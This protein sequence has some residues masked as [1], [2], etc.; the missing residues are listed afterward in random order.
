[1]I[2]GRIVLAV[3]GLAFGG[4]AV[5]QSVVPR[6]VRD[7]L[8]HPPARVPFGVG[9]VLDYGIAVAFARGNARLEV[10]SIDTIRGRPAYHAQFTLRGGV[11]LFRVDEKYNTWFDVRT[12]STL[13]YWEDLHNSTYSRRRRYEF[14]PEQHKF[15]DGLDTAT[16]VEHP[17]DQAAVFYLIRTLN[18]RVGLDTNLY[19]YFQM[20]RNPIRI[21][22]LGKER[23]KVDAGEFDAL[24][25]HPVIK[26]SGLFAQGGEAK[27]WISDDDRRIVLQVK[28]N[29]PGPLGTLTLKL[30]SYR[31]PNRPP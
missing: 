2:L 4:M 17:I 19:N 16:T 1:V 30:R 27:V 20:D 10:T 3:A 5:S 13:Q 31:P 15:T 6:D 28:A 26:T 22:V 12:I 8:E 11:P 25:V 18:L 14:L 23:I 9:E 24:V 29:V 7:K 21:Q